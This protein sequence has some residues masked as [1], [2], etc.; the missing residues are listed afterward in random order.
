M[1]R[2]LQDYFKPS[3]HARTV[4]DCG[5]NRTPV[6]VNVTLL[7]TLPV[8]A[9]DELRNVSSPLKT[10]SSELFSAPL[11]CGKEQNGAETSRLKR[12]SAEFQ[13]LAVFSGLTADVWK[14]SESPFC[15]F[16]FQIK[17]VCVS[18]VDLVFLPVVVCLLV[19]VF[20][21]FVC[22]LVLYVNIYPIISPIYPIILQ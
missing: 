18:H 1:S 5:S 8:D 14:S 20:L 3:C 22:F 10:D 17:E 16:Y 12:N 21:E 19:E 11:S 13:R 4:R 2:R 15:H 7:F 6:S 9:E